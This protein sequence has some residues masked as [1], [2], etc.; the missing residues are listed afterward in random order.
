M[1]MLINE[2]SLKYCKKKIVKIAS[3]SSKWHTVYTTVFAKL[4]QSQ[5]L[6]FALLFFF[7]DNTAAT[8]STAKGKLE[9]SKGTIN[10]HRI[11]G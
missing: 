9:I 6:P 8:L 4:L 11:I 3:I 7:N 10:F 5:T 2:V 1:F